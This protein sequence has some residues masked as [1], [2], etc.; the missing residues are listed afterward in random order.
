MINPK[1]ADR[2]NLFYQDTNIMVSV[3][4]HVYTADGPDFQRMPYDLEDFK[5]EFIDTVNFVF[6]N[7]YNLPE[8]LPAREFFTSLNQRDMDLYRCERKAMEN[9]IWA[10]PHLGDM[11][12]E[13]L[14]QGLETMT[15]ITSLRLPIKTTNRILR[16]R[17]TITTFRSA[18]MRHL[19][20]NRLARPI[21]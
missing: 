3:L 9:M 19:P 2:T 13:K 7:R 12:Q 17:S 5:Q 6:P 14:D 1:V 4:S 10:D 20:Q 15:S 21:N 11:I 8:D 18:T 16:S